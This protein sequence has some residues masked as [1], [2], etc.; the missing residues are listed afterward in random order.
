M[1]QKTLTVKAKKI[2]VFKKSKQGFTGKHDTE[3]TTTMI[4]T[5]TATSGIYGL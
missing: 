5:A 4:T 3:P 2:F 1:K